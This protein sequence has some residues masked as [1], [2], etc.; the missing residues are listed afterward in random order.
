MLL[1]DHRQAFAA[2]PTLEN[3]RC[4]WRQW[5]P[6]GPVD[7]DPGA[8]DQDKAAVEAWVEFANAD[9]NEMASA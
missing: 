1:M 3:Y 4:R 5:S 8:S 7:F 6:E 2:M 9:V